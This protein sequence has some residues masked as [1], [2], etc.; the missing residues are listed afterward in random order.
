MSLM[1]HSHKRIWRTDQYQTTRQCNSYIP[2]GCH[3]LTQLVACVTNACTNIATALRVDQA[4]RVALEPDLWRVFTTSGSECALVVLA[5]IL[6]AL[7]HRVLLLFGN[8]LAQGLHDELHLC[9]ADGC[10]NI[11]VLHVF[12]Q[13]LHGQVRVHAVTRVNHR[14]LVDCQSVTYELSSRALLALF[15]GKPMSIMVLRACSA[16][17]NARLISCCIRCAGVSCGG[18]GIKDETMSCTMLWICS[19]VGWGATGCQTVS[20]R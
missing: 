2:C 15:A 10:V 18:G 7:C 12:E 14:V 20:V 5:C 11:R 9:I 8:G 6:D 13:P 17:G 1:C 3:W 19:V 4:T 16:C